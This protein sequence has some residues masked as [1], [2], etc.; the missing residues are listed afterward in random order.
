M[1][2]LL[3]VSACQQKPAQ[4]PAPGAD[5]PQAAAPQVQNAFTDHVNRGITTMNK[6]E[7]VA[8][9]ENARIQGV[10]QQTQTPAE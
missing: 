4:E 8:A 6:A 1:A 2:G 10:Q 9:A 5:A 7:K 3:F